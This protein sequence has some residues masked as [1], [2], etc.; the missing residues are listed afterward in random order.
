M[1]SRP[2]RGRPPPQVKTCVCD[3]YPNRPSHL[4]NCRAFATMEGRLI[5]MTHWG[6]VSQSPPPLPTHT[7][8]TPPLFPLGQKFGFF[9]SFNFERQCDKLPTWRHRATIFENELSTEGWSIFLS[10]RVATHWQEI[11][12][13]GLRKEKE[14]KMG[15]NISCL[16]KW[17]SGAVVLLMH[18]RPDYSQFFHLLSLTQS[19]FDCR[20]L[21]RDNDD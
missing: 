6:L 8:I 10:S 16:S 9:P 5:V 19:C 14:S 21:A 17:K 1:S 15:T 12:P 20:I 11:G 18:L 2:R 13:K 4:S 7:H 3:C